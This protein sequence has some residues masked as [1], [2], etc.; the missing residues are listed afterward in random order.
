MNRCIAL[1]TV[2]ATVALAVTAEPPPPNLERALAIQQQRV[3]ER[4]DAASLND[5]G[6]LLVLASRHEEAEEA[7][8]RAIELSPAD[9]S[10]RFN[11]GLLLQQ[12]GR[13]RAAQTEYR[14]ILAL[15]PDHAWAHY[16]IGVILAGR[17]D[18]R[19]ALDHY[20]L[21]LALDPTL[22][23]PEV[24]PHII[25]NK[26]FS[27]ALLL[28]QKHARSSASSVA[29]TYGEPDLIAGLLL[30]DAAD[31]TDGTDGATASASESGVSESAAAADSGS[32]AR[33]SGSA[34]PLTRIE[35]RA[36]SGAPD[37][38]TTGDR[39][40]GVVPTAPSASSAGSRASASTGSDPRPPSTRTRAVPPVV[41]PV[42]PA[43][44]AESPARG[45]TDSG[46][47][48]VDESSIDPDSEVGRTVQPPVPPRRPRPFP[49][50]RDPRAQERL[51]RLRERQ[52][53]PEPVPD[54]DGSPSYEP[55]R[56]STAQLDT[57]LLPP[58]ADTSSGP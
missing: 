22:A 52:S 25:D 6:N 21:A 20:S 28:S 27:E 13:D 49:Y 24:N 47:R 31:G 2:L 37:V 23:F 56:R 11:L 17:Q 4:P 51:E 45:P 16:Q 44:V 9:T 58:E 19:G 35:S 41:V 10:V 8:R 30:E 46:Q 26:L 57:E 33:D 7:Y 29:R 14:E 18:R 53:R 43:P 42:V 54:D 5:L 40:D 39:V 34:G 36:E 50:D 3:A 38:L 12:M 48:V 32:G 15:D 1:V 55:S